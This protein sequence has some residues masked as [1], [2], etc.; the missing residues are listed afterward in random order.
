MKKIL[1]LMGCF[2]WLNG[3]SQT[4]YVVV[5]DTRAVNNP[6][7]YFKTKLSVD[8][9]ETT[10]IGAPGS[11]FFTTLLTV[12]PWH[13]DSGGKNHQLGFNNDGL[14]Y[15]IGSHSS[16]TWEPWRR[17][18]IEDPNGN[19]GIG[20]NTT[21]A[22]LDVRGGFAESSYGIQTPT[23]NIFGTEPAGVNKGSCIALGG[24]TGNGTPDYPFAYVFAGK[25][26]NAFDSYAGY[27]AIRTVSGNSSGEVNSANYERLR[28]TSLGNVGIG[29]TNPTEKLSVKGKIRAQEIKVELTGWADFVFAKDYKLPTLAETE[30]HIKEKGHLPGIP[31]AA[32]VKENGVELGEMNK[33]LLQKIEELTLH[34]IEM[35]K[36]LKAQR[37]LMKDR[38]NNEE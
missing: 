12:A 16:T 37:K 3:K 28:I 21:I 2:L 13:D 18:V 26:S 8:F 1:V 15:R 20:T 23:V 7:T 32:E 33:K 22:K 38:N 17:M 30:T 10:T 35:D 36:E 29:T 27:F 31:S 6:P 24:K 14:F 19:V 11:A 9:K 25:E 34:L 4:N 5:Q